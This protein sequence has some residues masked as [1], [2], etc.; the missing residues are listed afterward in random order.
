VAA[1]AAD[2]E[3]RA[4]LVGGAGLPVGVADAH[5]PAVLAHEV[6]DLGGHHDAE[7]PRLAGG[8]D[9]HVE[10]VPLRYQGDVPVPAR[11]AVEPRGDAAA[12]EDELDPALDPVRQCGEPLTQPELVEQSERRGVHGVAAEVAQEVGVLLQHHDVDAASGQQQ[13]EHD[14]RRT[15][16]DGN[17]TSHQASF[18]IGE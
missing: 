17:T 9:E 4:Q 3:L 14:P 2:D 8:V 18:V 15:A 1:V 13:A 16:A 6:V 12:V 7:V 5:D 10:E 11:K